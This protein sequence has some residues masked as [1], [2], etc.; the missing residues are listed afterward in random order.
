MTSSPVNASDGPA[1]KLFAASG[2]PLQGAED[3]LSVATDIY[4]ATADTNANLPGKCPRSLDDDQHDSSIDVDISKHTQNDMRPDST[5]C[6]HQPLA[7]ATSSTAPPLISGSAS[8]PDVG[9]AQ[10]DGRQK[11]EHELTPEPSAATAS[12]THST[13]HAPEAVV[14]S[15]Q[16]SDIN[17]S[18]LDPHGAASEHVKQQIPSDAAHD[19]RQLV[20]IREERSGTGEIAH[21]NS[22]NQRDDSITHAES[23]SNNLNA[24][25]VVC[26]RSTCIAVRVLT[27]SLDPAA[28]CAQLY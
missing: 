7:E 1:D 4:Q 15:E 25:H 16:A 20:V 21:D 13:P 26:L 6:S 17:E 23:L 10:M 28:G 18:E 8:S 2:A 3:A 14:L 11:A 22:R 19:A 5:A 27:C 12:D 9:T 24:K